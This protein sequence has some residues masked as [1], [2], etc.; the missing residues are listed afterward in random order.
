M[1]VSIAVI[2]EATV[3]D[4]DRCGMSHGLVGLLLVTPD[5]MKAVSDSA[6]AFW[7]HAACAARQRFEQIA[8]RHMSP[9][10]SSSTSTLSTA[11]GMKSLGFGRLS[12]A[13]KAALLEDSGQVVA[14]S[15]FP[16]LAQPAILDP[17]RAQPGERVACLLAGVVPSHG[18][19]REE[20]LAQR[21][22]LL[23][24]CIAQPKMH[25]RVRLSEILP[26][27]DSDCSAPAT[28]DRAFS[29]AVRPVHVA[30]ELLQKAGHIGKYGA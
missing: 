3:E 18:V 5:E 2:E 15:L 4:V 21:M 6:G 30:M 10:T 12:S 1:N 13:S 22:L 14:L 25:R 8:G 11:D 29:L 28:R 17:A 9:E 16:S 23:P 26:A 27:T 24:F 19:A 7:C 20:A